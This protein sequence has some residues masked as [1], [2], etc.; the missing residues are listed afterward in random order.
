M[1]RTSIGQ[2]DD[3]TLALVLAATT[4]IDGKPVRPGTAAAT[5]ASPI[6]AAP[7][8]KRMPVKL[9][10]PGFQFLF[11]AVEFTLAVK[12]DR[13]LNVGVVRKAGF[14]RGAKYRKAWFY[15]FAPRMLDCCFLV[16]A[17]HNGKKVYVTINRLGATMDDDNLQAASKEL[18]DAIALSFGMDDSPKSPLVW[19]YTQHRRAYYGA[20]VTLS[21]EEP[22]G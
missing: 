13:Q 20:V 5:I 7:K 10:K 19:N 16:G 22:N 15:A 8:T 2:I 12:L 21:L 1:P 4:R 3:A 14:G 17:A 11:N 18:R 9:I 6:R